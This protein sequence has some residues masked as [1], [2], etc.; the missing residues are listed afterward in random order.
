MYV[1][2]NDPGT[3]TM[4]QGFG[5]SSRKPGSFQLAFS[6]DGGNG[7]G[8]SWTYQAAADAAGWDVAAAATRHLLPIILQRRQ[9]WMRPG[10]GGVG[11]RPP[12]RSPV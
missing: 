10:H 11:G 2:D 6:S 4:I 3:I 9:G 12:P 7:G 1:I 8:C 5:F